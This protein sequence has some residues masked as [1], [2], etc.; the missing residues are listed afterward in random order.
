MGLSCSS[1]SGIDLENLSAS[2]EHFLSRDFGSDGPEKRASQV[3]LC[4]LGVQS[5][6][7][8]SPFRTFSK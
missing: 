1:C 7:Q 8:S 2:G 6:S 4:V 5:A 3:L